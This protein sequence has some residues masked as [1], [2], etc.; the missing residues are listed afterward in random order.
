V[1]I[2]SSY[3]FISPNLHLVLVKFDLYLVRVLFYFFNPNPIS[4]N[5]LFMACNTFLSLIVCTFVL[6]LKICEGLGSNTKH[7]KKR[8]ASRLELAFKSADICK[9]FANPVRNNSLKWSSLVV[10]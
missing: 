8:K 1:L 5:S 4:G 7:D 6:L 2:G 9:M 3:S 10:Y